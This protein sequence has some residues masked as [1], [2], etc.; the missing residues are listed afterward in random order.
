MINVRLCQPQKITSKKPTFI[1]FLESIL[2]QVYTECLIIKK[3]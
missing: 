3:T 2:A 1:I